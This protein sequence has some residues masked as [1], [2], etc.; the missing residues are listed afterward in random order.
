MLGIVVLLENESRKTHFLQRCQESTLK[1]LS[2]YLLIGMWLSPESCSIQIFGVV[3]LID[4][5]DD[6]S[7]AI[8]S[9]ML[10][11]TIRTVFLDHAGDSALRNAQFSSYLP[12]LPGSSSETLVIKRHVDK[13]FQFTRICIEFS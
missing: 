7:S 5:R 10:R 8:A 12:L 9:Q 2:K 11:G 6:R 4:S 3:F 1:S 13:F